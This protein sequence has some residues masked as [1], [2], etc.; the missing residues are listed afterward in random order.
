MITTFQSTLIFNGVSNLSSSYSE[1]REGKDIVAIESKI[2][3]K[4]EI[5][6]FKNKATASHGGG[7]SLQQSELDIQGHCTISDNY[8]VRG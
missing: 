4:G 6:L 8:A 2:L 3:V 5:K 1:A 7:M